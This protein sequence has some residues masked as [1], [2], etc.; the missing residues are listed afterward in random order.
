MPCP[1][2]QSGPA[3]PAALTV[4]RQREA[5]AAAGHV[6]TSQ[7]DCRGLFRRR[8]HCQVP[9][10]CV[11]LPPKGTVQPTP[12][13]PPGGVGAPRLLGASGSFYTGAAHSVGRTKQGS[14]G[15]AIPYGDN[16]FG[17]RSRAS[18]AQKSRTGEFSL[19]QPKSC[20]FTYQTLTEHLLC[21]LV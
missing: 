20:S 14:P 8:A 9:R 2:P 21:A 6:A 11:H 17:Q 3:R 7:V 16:R 19:L 12:T 5:A 1:Q 10:V 18:L 15:P 4:D 13:A